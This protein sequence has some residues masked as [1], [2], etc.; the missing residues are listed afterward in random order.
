MKTSSEDP[1]ETLSL[2]RWTVG[3]TL[4]AGWTYV[5]IIHK[6]FTVLVKAVKKKK[7]ANKTPKPPRC[8]KIISQTGKSANVALEVLLTQPLT[9]CFVQGCFLYKLLENAKKK[10]PFSNLSV[11]NTKIAVGKLLSTAQKDTTATRSF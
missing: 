11:K 7:K 1:L 2:Q 4:W 10:L 6:D 8:T 9:F 5:S 3:K